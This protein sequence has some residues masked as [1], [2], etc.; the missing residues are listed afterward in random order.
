MESPTVNAVNVT[1]DEG[2]ELQEQQQA[3]SGDT[4]ARKRIAWYVVASSLV[5]LKIKLLNVNHAQKKQTTCVVAVDIAAI[6]FA[7]LAT[8]LLLCS[9]LP[10]VTA[11]QPV[12]KRWPLPASSVVESFP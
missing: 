8:H 4:S 1:R 2:Q 6:L 5:R 11:M 10:M 7:W 12:L 9:H 3:S